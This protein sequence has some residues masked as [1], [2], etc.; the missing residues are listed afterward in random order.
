MQ[1][2]L[3]LARRQLEQQTRTLSA[4]SPLNTL[5]R[6]YSITTREQG[7]LIREASQV[8]PG[9]AVEIRLQQGRLLCDVRETHDS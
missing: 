4:V 6:G 9:D 5:Q 1:Q 2:R 7:E 8:R 3:Q